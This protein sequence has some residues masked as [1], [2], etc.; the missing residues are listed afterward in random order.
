MVYCKLSWYF[1]N[2]LYRYMLKKRVPPRR[3]R[4]PVLQHEGSGTGTF[5]RPSS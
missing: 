5:L 4:V 3:I 1:F 2:N